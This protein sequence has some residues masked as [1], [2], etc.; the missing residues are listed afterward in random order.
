[1]LCAQ[2][3]VA[4]DACCL[5]IFFPHLAELVVDKATD[6]G[7]YVLVTAHTE[8]GPAACRACGTSSSAGPEAMSKVCG[9]G[10]AMLPGYS[11]AA[12]STTG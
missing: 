2:H 11:W 9:V 6:H 8:S 5:R 7:D 1:M 10:M 12:H 4:G 3:A